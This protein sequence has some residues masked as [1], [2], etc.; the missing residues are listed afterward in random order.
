MRQRRTVEVRDVINLVNIV[1]A[2]GRET[3]E[4]R[5]AVSAVL[6][7]ILHSTGNYAGFGYTDNVDD[8]MRQYY[9]HQNLQK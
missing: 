4:A 6:S 3:R 1:L 5:M 9:T 7:A 2:D 8:S